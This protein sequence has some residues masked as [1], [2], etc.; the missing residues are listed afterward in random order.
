MQKEL[1]Q[2]VREWNAH[3]NILSSFTPS[4]LLMRVGPLL[5]GLR[6]ESVLS[7]S[8]R[9]LF[10]MIPLWNY[11][12]KFSTIPLL[13]KELVK[14]SGLQFFIK[15]SSHHDVFETALESVDLQ[16]GELLRNNIY[17]EDILNFIS[18]D[19]KNKRDR[20][21]PV[22]EIPIFELKLALSVFLDDRQMKED[23]IN[24]IN[25]EAAHWD[26]ASFRN[27]YKITPKNW[28]KDFIIRFDDANLF[29]DRITTNLARPKI[30]K[31]KDARILIAPTLN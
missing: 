5:A 17:L 13:S 16:F 2:I 1:R 4:T 15:Y 14:K 6:F 28:A 23:V 26:E 11:S 7:G 25:I 8:Y 19:P 30:A 3:F 22:F 27:L 12:E 21:N 31:L 10:E 18:Q 29:F 24:K 20:N 9:V